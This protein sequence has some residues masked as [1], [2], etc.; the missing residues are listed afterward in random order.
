MLSFVPF[1]SLALS[2]SSAYLEDRK[3]WWN[4]ILYVSE[5]GY[6]IS[7]ERE[8]VSPISRGFRVGP[9]AIVQSHHRL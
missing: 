7:W 5:P 1:S 9:I 2:E 8:R 4:G 6:Q 3:T